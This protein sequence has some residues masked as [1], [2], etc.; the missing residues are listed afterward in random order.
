[1]ER[2]KDAELVSLRSEVSK[3]QNDIADARTSASE[4]QNRLKVDLDT[5]NREHKSLQ[6]TYNS[7]LERERAASSKLKEVT[8]NLSAAE[9]VK[10]SLES[11]LQSV[12]SRQNDIDSQ[13]AEVQRAKEAGDFPL[14]AYPQL[15]LLQVLERQTTTSQAKLTDYE[16]TFIQLERDKAASER[17]L[18]SVREQLKAET[19]KRAESERLSTTRKQ[20]IA[21]LKDRNI[22]LDRDLNKALTDIKNLEWQNKQL[23]SKQDK[24]IVEHVHV[25]E[26]AKRVTDRQLAEAQLE[27]QKN[28]T[29]ITSLEKTKGRLSREI[30]DYARQTEQEGVEISKKEKAIR[31]Q[32]QKVAQA[33]AEAEKERKSREAGEMRIKRLQEDLQNSQR[34]IT[35]V[36]QQAMAV[37][38]SKDNLETELS[39]LADSTESTSMAKMQ[40]QYEAKISQLESQLEDAEWSKTT[41]TRIREQINRQHAEIR[42]LIMTSGP[43][44]ESFRTRLLKELQ[45]ADEEMEQEF[46]TRGQIRDTGMRSLANVTPQKRNPQTNG[47]SRSRRD[48]QPEPS[49]TSDKQATVLRQQLQVLELRM[50]ASDR[51]REHLENSLNE[52]NGELDRSD[53][54]I[55]SLE[56]YKVK[57]ARENKRLLELLEDE[58]EARRAAEAAQIGGDKELWNKFQSTIAGERESY[59]RLEESRKALVSGVGCSVH[60]KG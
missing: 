39:R 8:A 6:Q 20:E 51:V 57:M 60:V 21:T 19:T 50:A 16:D 43:K 2:R 58:R 5:I 42:R 7:L 3:L 53:G 22:K 30:E 52:L 56:Q 17:H 9:K 13:L 27:L 23:E 11:D 14:C 35:D 15:I 55:H 59:A 24:T 26:E 54:S 49:K 48:S 46:A 34:R 4:A 1:M 18:E 37:Q 45:L 10:R 31:I 47:S 28:A 44:D 38:R 40:R 32:E 33:L 25:L 36:T 12:R 29:Y 41:A